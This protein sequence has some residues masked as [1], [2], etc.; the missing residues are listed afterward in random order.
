MTIQERLKNLE[1]LNQNYVPAKLINEIVEL[2]ASGCPVELIDQNCSLDI[3]FIIHR[4]IN[5]SRRPGVERE[6]FEAI[7]KY[8]YNHLKINENKC[9][10]I[11]DTHIGRLMP[12][13]SEIPLL[14]GINENEKGLMNAY[15]FALDNNIHTVLHAGDLIE[16]QSNKKAKRYLFTTDQKNYLNRVYPNIEGIRT[17]LLYGNHDINSVHNDRICGKIIENCPQIELIGA[18]YSYVNFNGNIIKLSHPVDNYKYENIYLNNDLELAGHSHMSAI[19]EPLRKMKLPALGSTLEGDR[20]FIELI[21]EE[22]EYLL[23]EYDDNA[24]YRRELTIKKGNHV[25]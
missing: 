7:R 6:V 2:C 20:G 11:S 4:L 3:H 23:K 1:Y 10:V 15:Q 8:Y 19:N 14:A 17:L 22:N 18:S 5:Y 25:I 9:L 21:D 13:E 16:G 12:H 24:S